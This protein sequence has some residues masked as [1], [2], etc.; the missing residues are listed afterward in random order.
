M[1]LSKETI[2]PLNKSFFAIPVPHAAVVLL[3]PFT[4]KCLYPVYPNGLFPSLPSGNIQML[5]FLANPHKM[6]PTPCSLI[7]FYFS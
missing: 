7:R 4:K 3:V 6:A 2:S 5:P 1:S